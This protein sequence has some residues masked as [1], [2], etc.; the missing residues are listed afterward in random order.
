MYSFAASASPAPQ[1]KNIERLVVYQSPGTNDRRIIEFKDF[2]LQQ[3]REE[4]TLNNGLK[5]QV[6][7][8]ETSIS[9][10]VN[11]GDWDS[12]V[13]APSSAS[14]VNSNYVIKFDSDFCFN[15]KSEM[16]TGYAIKNKA[17]FIVIIALTRDNGV[18]VPAFLI[19]FTIK[20]DISGQ[21]ENFSLWVEA[22]CSDQTKQFI[23]GST[24][25]RL[26]LALCKMFN[27][28]GSFTFVN[29]YLE[30]LRGVE[31]TYIKHG[32]ESTTDFKPDKYTTALKRKISQT[33][34]VDE[35]SE[36]KARKVE[37]TT[38][39]DFANADLGNVEQ[40]NKLADD[41]DSQEITWVI[42][43]IGTRTGDVSKISSVGSKGG[44]SRKSK[45]RKTM[46]KRKSKKSRKYRFK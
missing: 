17:N 4:I 37:K 25:L 26:V 27:G 11:R 10:V 29:S 16:N 34:S 41:W 33:Q 39:S 20:P 19:T 21:S 9:P 18:E 28:T 43:K 38:A 23:G 36:R 1:L 3:S 44:K 7:I 15:D 22:L 42:D 45:R 6:P 32:Y 24:L 8:N 30:A 2:I 40:E 12:R 35:I 14:V 13:S 31:P 5:I 46:K